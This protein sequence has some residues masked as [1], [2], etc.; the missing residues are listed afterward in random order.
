MNDH[1]VIHSTRRSLGSRLAALSLTLAFAAGLMSLPLED[2]RAAGDVVVEKIAG[3]FDKVVT[4]LRR[5]I[6]GHKL[7]IVKEVP[8]Q[9]MLAM[10]GTKSGPMIG[11]E[12]FH[13]RYG[14]VLFETDPSAFKEAP[15]RMVVRAS[16]SDVML[17]YRK[18]SAVF[19]S[20][21]SLGA[22]GQELDEVF[23]DIVKRVAQ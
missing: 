13:P 17:E 18:P 15:L 10:V 23:A 4:G 5:E 16:G 11:I 3:P 12:I 9:K 20:Y 19:A 22:L 2:A 1:Q 6:A 8:Y 7:V 21:R 14:K